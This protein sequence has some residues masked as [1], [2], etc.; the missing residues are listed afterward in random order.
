MRADAALMAAARASFPPDGVATSLGFAAHGLELR[1]FGPPDE[2]DPDA[3]VGAARDAF[4]SGVFT[5]PVVS[6]K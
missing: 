3:L 1:V 4:E 5:M 6:A 2:E